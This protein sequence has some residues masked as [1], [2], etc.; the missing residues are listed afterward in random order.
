MEVE[1]RKIGEKEEGSGGRARGRRRK[2]GV[3]GGVKMR[4]G[5]KY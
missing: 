1:G 4:S 3:K 5:R 2:G